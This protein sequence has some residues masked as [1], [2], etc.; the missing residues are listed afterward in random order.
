MYFS[1]ELEIEAISRVL[2]NKKLFR[3]QGKDVPSECSTFENAFAVYL[4][5]QKSILLSSGTNALV[6]ALFC[7]G[8]KP[9]DE[10]LI[11]AYT[12]FATA[13][14]VIEMQA[15]PIVVNI[16]QYLSFDRKDLI[17]KFSDKTRAL[18]AV[19]MD[20]TP[21]DMNHLESFC[22]ENNIALIEDAAQ[23]V[24]GSYL[25]K[26]LGSIGQFG[27]F[28][29]NVDKIISCGEGGAISINDDQ[30]YQKAFLYHDTCNQFG[31]TS[32]DLYTISKFS[33]KSMRAS[34]IQG[35]MINVQLSRLNNILYELKTRKMILDSHLAGLGLTLIKTYDP[36]G[37]C[38]TM[39]RVQCSDPG[40]VNKYVL[41]LNKIGIRSNSPMLRPAHHVWQWQSLL[42]NSQN[43]FDFLPSIDLLSRVLLI[44]VTLDQSLEEWKTLVEGISVY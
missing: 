16:D 25:G 14:A 18:I 41:E 12:F 26:K 1:D 34:E 28:S 11:P 40:M 2:K 6:N 36:T 42:N 20:G 30:M 21:C 10:V 17:A 23:A 33:G 13:A 8:I 35:A 5:S 9:G 37:E 32:K 44:H 27:C 29:F 19:H 22:K 4:N 15:I 7:I 24:G 3:Y 43:K 38:C 39:S 31:P